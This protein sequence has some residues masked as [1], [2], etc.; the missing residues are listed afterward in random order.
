MDL[1]KQ[2]QK[3]EKSKKKKKKKK[4]LVAC[5]RPQPS[6]YDERQLYA[7]AKAASCMIRTHHTSW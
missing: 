5:V 6:S 4:M 2:R 3:Q 1:Q 7:R